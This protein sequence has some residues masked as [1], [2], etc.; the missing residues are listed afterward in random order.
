MVGGL[1]RGGSKG[2]DQEGGKRK[3]GEAARQGMSSSV[4][5]VVARDRSELDRLA[6]DPRWK[7]L[8]RDPGLRTWTDEFSNILS[9]IRWNG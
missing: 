3:Q 1:R 7:P 2:G 8:R 5:A 4:W 6:R 9:V